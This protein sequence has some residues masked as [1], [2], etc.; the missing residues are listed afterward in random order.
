[1]SNT[2]VTHMSNYLFGVL[3]KIGNKIT[4]HTDLDFFFLTDKLGKGVNPTAIASRFLPF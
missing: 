2:R 4:I 1:M 3:K